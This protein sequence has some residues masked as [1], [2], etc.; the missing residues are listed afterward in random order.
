[1]PRNGIFDHALVDD[2]RSFG[3]QMQDLGVEVKKTGGLKNI[4]WLVTRGKAAPLANK[5]SVNKC[6]ISLGN[7]VYQELISESKGKKIQFAVAE[8][9]GQKVLVIKL[10]DTGYKFVVNKKGLIRAGSPAIVRKI[11][12]HGL[13]L[14]GYK[15]K[16]VKG[17]II[18]FPEGGGAGGR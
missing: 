13:P 15:V 7:E 16:K 8:F 14:G 10:S 12:A 5:I 11:Q 4:K 18:C 6:S 17:G 1:M 3:Q 9:S 2:D